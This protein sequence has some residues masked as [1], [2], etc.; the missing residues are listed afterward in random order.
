MAILAMAILAIAL[1]SHFGSSHFGGSGTPQAMPSPPHAGAEGEALCDFVATDYGE[2]YLSFVKG[3]RLVWL[4]FT[5]MTEGWAWGLA[6]PLG[7]N[8]RHGWFSPSHWMPKGGLA[9]VMAEVDREREREREEAQ[10]MLQ[11][12]REEANHWREQYHTKQ[13][14]E[15]V[16]SE[17]LRASEAECET[18]AAVLRAADERFS[19][20]TTD[21][22]RA[23][24]VVEARQFAAESSAV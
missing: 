2:G 24:A 10:Q 1:R 13:R 19:T 6:G 11:R 18:H 3:E 15:L 17:A 7:P 21:L 20:V 9:H 5:N 12:A 8:E 23:E 16:A 22:R 4:G 14:Q